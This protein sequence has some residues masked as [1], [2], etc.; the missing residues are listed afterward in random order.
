M[1]VSICM[2]FIVTY[3]SSL[4]EAMNG[5]NLIGIL[6]CKSVLLIPIGTCNLYLTFI[7]ASS[8]VNMGAC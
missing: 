6:A 7:Y 4:N 3:T 5:I 8:H 1:A 2:V